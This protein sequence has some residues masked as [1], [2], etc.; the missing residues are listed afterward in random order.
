MCGFSHAVSTLFTVCR[1][2]KSS[3]WRYQGKLCLLCGKL[4]RKKPLGKIG[5]GYFIVLNIHNLTNYTLNNIFFNLS[6]EAWEYSWLFR[7]PVQHL[8]PLFWMALSAQI[9]SPNLVFFGRRE[10]CLKSSAKHTDLRTRYMV[11]PINASMQHCPAAVG[12]P[13]GLENTPML[14]TLGNNRNQTYVYSLVMCKMGFCPDLGVPNSTVFKEVKE[15]LKSR[16][17]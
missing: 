16:E 17:V 6:Y 12:A 13:G 7:N 14:L 5:W 15:P 11:M 10:G 2:F 9:D 8:T 4:L 1:Q 3:Y